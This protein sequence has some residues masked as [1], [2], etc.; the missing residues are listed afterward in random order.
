MLVYMLASNIINIGCQRRTAWAESPIAKKN[1]LAS[2]AFS[3]FI[4]IQTATVL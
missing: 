1:V 3:V 2:V 4:S